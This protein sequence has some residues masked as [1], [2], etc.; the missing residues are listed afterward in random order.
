MEIAER[1]CHR[2]GIINQGKLI[3]VGSLAELREQAQLP[4]STLEDLFLSLT[5]SSSEEG[6]GA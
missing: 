1:L 5:G 6:N 2:I 4:G 3:A